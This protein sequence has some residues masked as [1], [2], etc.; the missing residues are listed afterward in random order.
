LNL[1]SSKLSQ[2]TTAM[3]L[4]LLIAG[5]VLSLS[6]HD[7]NHTANATANDTAPIVWGN[8][9]AAYNT[10]TTFQKKLALMAENQMLHS[11][12]RLSTG[13]L[14]DLRRQL[15]TCHPAAD[16]KFHD[17]DT[18]WKAHN[19]TSMGPPTVCNPGNYFMCGEQPHCWGDCDGVDPN[20]YY[21][22]YRKKT[23]VGLDC[24][25]NPNACTCGPYWNAHPSCNPEFEACSPSSLYNRRFAGCCCES[26]QCNVDWSSARTDGCCGCGH[27]PPIL[28]DGSYWISDGGAMQCW[29]TDA[30]TSTRPSLLLALLGVLLASAPRWWC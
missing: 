12:R 26:C 29:W 14:G 27:C 5:S 20:R 30:A 2:L 7:Y 23:C 24:G 18:P 16:P 8:S 28:A 15:D 22:C 17:P 1:R 6:D 10:T 9:T 19:V 13:E 11:Q 25:V 4:V 21:R 3:L